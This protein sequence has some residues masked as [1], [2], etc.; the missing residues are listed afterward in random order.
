M[1]AV[2]QTAQVPYYH[3]NTDMDKTVCFISDIHSQHIKL[4]SALSWISESFD[5][6]HCIFLGDIMDSRLDNH[7][8]NY[9]PYSNPKV[10]FE[11]VQYTVLAGEGVL[12]QSN[13]QE[14]LQRF[15]EHHLA[16]TK[17]NPV[18]VNYGLNYTISQFIDH[19]TVE[20]KQDLHGWLAA[21][22]YHVVIDSYDLQHDS[23][24]SFLCSHAYFNTAA[25]LQQPSKRHKQEALYGLLDD[26]NKRVDW[27]SDDNPI[28]FYGFAENAV[29]VAGHYHV[30]FQGLNNRVIDSGCGSTGGSLCIHV[31]A[32]GIYKEF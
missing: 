22:P 18:T 3:Y 4:E 25:N 21:L 23:I 6:P 8:H 30:N 24:T 19:L 13:H 1:S 11:M 26:D 16:G 28:S 12:L 2:D 27:W 32:Y 14:K 15:L 29:R 17:P 9:P 31:P 20:E 10:A 5:N 7:E